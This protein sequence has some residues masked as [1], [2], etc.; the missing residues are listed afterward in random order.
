MPFQEL[1]QKYVRGKQLIS[2][3]AIVITMFGLVLDAITYFSIYSG[4]QIAVQSITL[5]ACVVA[6]AFYFVNPKKNYT[7]CFGVVSYG[8]V[9]NIIVTAT[10]IH[11]FQSFRF[12]EEANILSRDILFIVLYIVLSGFI[13]GRTHIFVQGVLLNGLIL[14][15]LLV[16]KDTFF[17]A[18]A[19]I[20]IVASLGFLYVL[21]F[22]VGTLDDLI[23]GLENAT[24]RATE[25]QRQEAAKKERLLNY[26]NSLLNLSRDESI[27][28]TSLLD[29]FD[30][31]CRSAFQNLGTSRVSVWILDEN[32]TKLV[33]KKLFERGGKQDETVVLERRQFP[34]YFRA[35]ETSPYINAVDAREHPETKEF[36]DHYLM[37]LNIVSMLDCPIVVN[38]VPLGVICCEHQLDRKEW[39][40]EDL[41]YVQSLAE[42]ISICYKNQEIKA[43]L[44]EVKKRNYE[45]VE[46]TNEI[47][48]MNEEL[49]SVNEQLSTLNDSLEATVRRRTAELETQNTQ[50]TEYA[51]INSH[52]LRAPLARILGLAQLISREANIK[53][54]Q[55]LDALVH[56]SD[57]LDLIIRKISDIL[58]SGNNLSRHDVKSIVDRNLPQN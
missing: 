27:F 46:K 40:A 1:D 35:L 17:V 22:F 50:L 5:M 48:T 11:T 8:I 15:F 54:R 53:D 7:I 42:H 23:Q 10:I 36:K 43:L 44:E 56:S 20:Y 14:Y 6:L 51:F 2:L 21:H 52:V 18:N 25:Y 41:L 57:E 55:L 24:R 30:K 32:N 19:P 33:R 9:L 26:Q 47:E 38:G 4:I 28:N 58:Y 45:L 34:A 31:I 29:V 13:L 16:K 49:N 37:P 39:S 12:F 3:A